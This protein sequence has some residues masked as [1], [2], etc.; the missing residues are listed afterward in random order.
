MNQAAALAKEPAGSAF[1]QL[2]KEWRAQ[3]KL[4]QLDLALICNVSQRHISFLESGRSQPS[5]MMVSLLAESL[6][7]S[8][9]DCNTLLQAAGYR[10]VFLERDLSDADMAPVKQALNLILEHHNPYPAIVVDRHWN[11]LDANLA[12]LTLFS[13]LGDINDLWR[14]VGG[15]RPNIMRLT[16]HQAGLRPFI[17]N[18]DELAPLMLQRLQREAIADNSVVL[19]A[20]VAELENDPDIPRDWIQH[21]PSKHLTPVVPMALEAGGLSVRLFSMLTTFGTPQDISTDEMRVECF[22]PMDADSEAQLR[23][24]C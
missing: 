19:Q 21:D 12:T 20:L 6:E 15:E 10:A 14:A 8:L 4:S 9:R 2:L 1:G 3:R 17:R 13:R 24:L 5:R 22:F 18:W 23:N 11:L 16:F 7:I